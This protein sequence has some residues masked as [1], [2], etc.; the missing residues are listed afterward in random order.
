MEGLRAPRQGAQPDRHRRLAF[1]LPGAAHN[2]LPHASD[3]A[4]RVRKLVNL[5][6]EVLGSVGVMRRGE[7]HGEIR[8]FATKTAHG[9]PGGL[10]RGSARLAEHRQS[11]SDLHAFEGI[12]ARSAWMERYC[13][14]AGGMAGGVAPPGMAG[15]LDWY[16]SQILLRWLWRYGM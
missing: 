9:S 3:Q 2:R 8:T 10:A 1:D 14:G 15:V 13:G 6:E 12:G 16:R 5:A 7:H 4:R 11:R